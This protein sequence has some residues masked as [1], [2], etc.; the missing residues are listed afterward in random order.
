LRTFEEMKAEYVRIAKAVGEEE[1]L[2]GY[3][4]EFDDAMN[5]CRQWDMFGLARRIIEMREHALHVGHDQELGE[6]AG[7][8]FDDVA[9]YAT[10]NC[11]CRVGAPP[12]IRL[13]EL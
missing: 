12:M 3:L 4:H 5:E 10:N 13:G 6:D 7:R 9:N 11:T 1:H 2:P 8:L